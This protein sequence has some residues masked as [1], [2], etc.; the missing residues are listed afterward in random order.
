MK[1]YMKPAIRVMAMDDEPLC[2]ASPVT[3][4]ETSTKPASSST[5]TLS[6]EDESRPVYSGSSYDVWAE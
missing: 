2:A 4:G 6:Q 1:T 5:S 3:G